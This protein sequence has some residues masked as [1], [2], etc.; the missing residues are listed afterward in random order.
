MLLSSSLPANFQPEAR[1]GL[2]VE[3]WHFPADQPASLK[4]FSMP[5]QAAP[6]QRHAYFGIQGEGNAGEPTAL[7]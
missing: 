1:P 7:L 6:T 2:K 3:K 4:G 5:E